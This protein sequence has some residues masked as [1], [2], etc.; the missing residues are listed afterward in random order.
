L[1]VSLS[2]LWLGQTLIQTGG[3]YSWQVIAQRVD[4]QV[5]HYELTRKARETP[6]D[7]LS[8]LLGPLDANDLTIDLLSTVEDAKINLRVSDLL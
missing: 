4:F 7:G 8:K 1:F 5:P 3:N 2:V 6:D